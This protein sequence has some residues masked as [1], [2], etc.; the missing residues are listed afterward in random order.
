MAIP[1][2]TFPLLYVV[3][4][5]AFMT[6]AIP[7][8]RLADRVGHETTFLLGYGLL[9]VVYLLLLLPELNAFLVLLI[10]MVLGGYYAATDGVLMALASSMLPPDLRATGLALLTTGTGLARL[11]ASALYGA[12]W[13]WLGVEPALAIFTL[14]LVGALVIARRRMAGARSDS[15]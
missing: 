12:A 15:R 4:A 5:L 9:A 2:S 14:S 3:T 7:V 13:T 6:L 1:T 10:L 11:L 8:G